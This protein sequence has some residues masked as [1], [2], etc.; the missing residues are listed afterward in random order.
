MTAT[1]L[2]LPVVGSS[3]VGPGVVLAAL[4]AAGTVALL[5]P[6]GRA[7]P[8]WPGPPLWRLPVTP[9]G[10]R[11]AARR[12]ARAVLEVCDLLAAELAA[13]RPPGDALSA[14]ARQWPPL[15]P[16]VE[17]FHLGADVPEAWRDLARR[18]PGAGDLRLV[19]AAWAVAH[20]TGHGLSHALA[21]TARGIRSRRRTRRVVESE[22]A[23][24]RATARLVA[25]LPLAALVMGAG[26]GG[27]PW[28]FLLGTPLGLAC[29]GLGVLLM[30]LGLLWIERIA[31]RAAPP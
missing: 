9:W 17:A 13:G 27:S 24:A 7:G 15:A 4:A 12:D 2:V 6:P 28:R 11:T 3:A 18:R 16:V 19:A 22:L 20:Q 25:A 26:A 14:A 30:L 29:L 31:D 10:R 21:R 5:V 23:S 1:L 8:S